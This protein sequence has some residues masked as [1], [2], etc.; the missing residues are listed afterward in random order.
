MKRTIALVTV[1][2]ALLAS[3]GCINRRV[4]NQGKPT[5]AATGDGLP[6]EP[7]AAHA[8]AFQ[9][10]LK[11]INPKLTVGLAEDVLKGRKVCAVIG[12][13]PDNPG[14][15]RG[16]VNDQFGQ[17]LEPT[18]EAVIAAAHEHLCPAWRLGGRK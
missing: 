17:L 1:A 11:K 8:A 12:K 15:Q 6:P 2:A 16:I 9:E 5:A 7:D 3:S 4:E 13:H 18:S 10:A 14:L